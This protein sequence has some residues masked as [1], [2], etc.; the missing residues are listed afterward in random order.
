MSAPVFQF[1]PVPSLV[2]SPSRARFAA[3]PP[4]PALPNLNT[5]PPAEPLP[6]LPPPPEALA[7][8]LFFPPK[9][10]SQSTGSS[11]Q[12]S[13]GKEGGSSGKGHAASSSSLEPSQPG[14]ST[15]AGQGGPSGSPGEQQS[16]PP[17]SPPPPLPEAAAKG[18][19]KAD[20][21]DQKGGESGEA[22]DTTSKTTV[23]VPIH[24]FDDGTIKL[25]NARL[26]DPDWQKRADA[27]MDF[28][29]VLESNPSLAKRP[30]YKPYV[31]AFALKILR[32][33]IAVVHE[34][35]LLAI[36]T[37][38]YKEPSEDV[39]G[40]LADLKNSSG[41]LGLEPQMIEDALR[42]LSDE[43]AEDAAKAAEKKESSA[44]SDTPSADDT[45]VP[46]ANELP[47][48]GS[49]SPNGFA[50]FPSF[51]QAQPGGS[52][53]KTPSAAAPLPQLST[54]YLSASQGLAPP[55]GKK[56]SLWPF[57]HHPQNSGMTSATSPGGQ[58][59]VMAS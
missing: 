29:L 4:Q 2:P 43:Q 10:A 41:L 15:P 11:S 47:A 21:G 9:P 8:W 5:L 27:A 19:D 26:E 35:M 13:G 32:D 3:T 16:P 24:G 56:F 33:P 40:D 7:P 53:A 45:P 36:E 39:M 46:A 50:P 34:P 18:L 54:P 1:S 25:L 52:S 38:L 20:N 58:L 17:G 23:G 55:R 22:K 57:Q 44:S 30:E 42:S 51:P 49:G 59:N 12:D 6:T 14:S 28:Y 31:D 48:A 37:G